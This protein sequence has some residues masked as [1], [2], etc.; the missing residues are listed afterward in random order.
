MVSLA[1]WGAPSSATPE[2]R[3]GWW[4]A[5]RQTARQ[6]ASVHTNVAT[7]SNTR[8]TRKTGERKQRKAPLAASRFVSA[9]YLARTPV[10][11]CTSRSASSATDDESCGKQEPRAANSSMAKMRTAATSIRPRKR[12]ARFRIW[13]LGFGVWDLSLVIGH[14]SFSNRRVAVTRPKQPV[15]ITSP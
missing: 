9:P 15:S 6:R 13:G 11:H 1:V 7:A 2:Q 3:T 8:S 10:S 5:L 4:N 12:Y 14:W